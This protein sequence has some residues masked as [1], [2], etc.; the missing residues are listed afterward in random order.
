[1]GFTLD[2]VEKW[3]GE[4]GMNFTRDRDNNDDKIVFGMSDKESKGMAFLRARENGDIFC[5]EFEPIDDNNKPL[6]VEQSHQHIN[7]L[8]MQ[9]LYQNY[10]TKFGTWEYDPN[11]GDIRFVVEIPLE[12]AKMTKNQFRRVLSILGDALEFIPKMKHILATGEVPEDEV[13]EDLMRAM[14]REFLDFMKSKKS[15]GSGDDKEGI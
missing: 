3:L 10:I 2:E 8:L 12:D 1:M 13:G 9:M 15:G 14:F 4:L 6:D 7:V 5:L 11:D